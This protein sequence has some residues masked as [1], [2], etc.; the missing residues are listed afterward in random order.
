KRAAE[1]KDKLRDAEITAILTSPFLRTQE[2]A[3]PLAEELAIAAR[4][5]GVPRG[6]N[7]HIADVA[8][9][10]RNHRGTAV[11]VVGHGDTVPA[12]IRRLGGPAL[13][14]LCATTFDVLFTVELKGG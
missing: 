2:T 14:D 10:V 1:L 7:Q 5:I 9:A 8:A 3:A 4:Q 11:L 12:V 6:F 13:K